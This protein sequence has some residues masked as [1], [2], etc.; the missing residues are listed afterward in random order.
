MKFGDKVV[1]RDGSKV[2]GCVG[3]VYRLD[4]ESACILLEKEVIWPVK[5]ESLEPVETA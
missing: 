4:E 3:V 1:I 2:D 5:K